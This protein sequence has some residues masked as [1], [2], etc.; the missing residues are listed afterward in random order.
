MTEITVSKDSIVVVMD[1]RCGLCAN[2]ARWIARHDRDNRFRIVPMQSGLGRHLFDAHGIDPDDPASWLYLEGGRALTAFDAWARVGQV[3]G[4]AA[5]ALVLL[6]AIPEPLR[7]KA[8]RLMARNRI[9]F[10]G[11]DN[12]CHMPD[13]DVERRLLL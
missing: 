8:Y 12:L 13:A 5:S 3:I 1:A 9:R 4:G 7:T 2:G 10:F 11:S 6:K